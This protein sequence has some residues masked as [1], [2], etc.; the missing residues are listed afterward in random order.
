MNMHLYQFRY[1]LKNGTG[2]YGYV[3]AADAR[4]VEAVARD[5]YQLSKDVVIWDI[6]RCKN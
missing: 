3:M 1:E 4:C 5:R 6:K 2:G